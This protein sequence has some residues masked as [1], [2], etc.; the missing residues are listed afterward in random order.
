MMTPPHPT[1]RPMTPCRLRIARTLLA[2]TTPLLLIGGCATPPADAPAPV[3]VKI[4]A[5]ND[6]HGNLQSPG[7]FAASAHA[8]ERPAVGGAD[9]LAAWVARLE[10]QNPNH[11]VVGVGDFVG[12]SP[13]VSA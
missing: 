1:D 12:A 4:V 5:F 6:F 13:L 10:S 2:T 7:R 8:A 3:R 9:A 11:V